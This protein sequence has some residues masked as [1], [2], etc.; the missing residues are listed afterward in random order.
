MTEGQNTLLVGATNQNVAANPTVR[1]QSSNAT[2]GS[3]TVFTPDSG[4]TAYFVTDM[5]SAYF[6][7]NSVKRGIRLLNGRKQVLLQDEITASASVMWR[8]HTNATVS[9]SGTSATLKIG[10]K[11]MDVSIL[12]APD[13]AV[14]TTSKAERMS[15]DGEFPEWNT[16]A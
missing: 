10:D 14:F 2:Q 12:N 13:G 5:T 6:N 8:I 3:S 1:A 16:Q 11:T 9:T 15:T 4:S 7:A